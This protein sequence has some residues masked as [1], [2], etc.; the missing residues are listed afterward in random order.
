MTVLN[1]INN[2]TKARSLP[3]S[4][5]WLFIF[6]SN[7]GGFNKFILGF[8]PETNAEATL[9]CKAAVSTSPMSCYFSLSGT[10]SSEKERMPS[11]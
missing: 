10:V 7:P 8:E 9:H 2:S 1:P 6:F 4:R 3:T 5:I 11:Q